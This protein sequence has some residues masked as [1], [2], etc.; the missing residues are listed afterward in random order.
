MS[1][2]GRRLPNDRPLLTASLRALYMVS[3]MLSP[4]V[5]WLLSLSTGAAGVEDKL[6]AQVAAFAHE[7]RWFSISIPV[8]AGVSKFFLEREDQRWV[9]HT[10][11]ALVTSY[12]EDLFGSYPGPKH[13]HRVT[14]FAYKPFALWRTFPWSRRRHPWSGWLVPV[15]RSNHT[16]QRVR[17]RFLAPDRAV[18]AEGV[19]GRAWAER[20][21]VT[22]SPLPELT[23]G[24]PR[25]DVEAYARDSRVSEG[26]LRKRLEGNEQLPRSLRGLHVEVGR[27]VW[28]VVVIDSIAEDAFG[29]DPSGLNRVN[30]RF[31][32][33]LSALLERMRA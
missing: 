33:N 19:A 12:Q 25:A 32:E 24:S 22:V 28:G 20:A 26:W 29:T 23:L 8:C 4:I 1:L 2:K 15:C 21:T 5:T 17:A 30:M 13:C 9:R 16:T 3:I 27:N 18:D 7:Y 31:I 6:V 10:V 14:L 11:H